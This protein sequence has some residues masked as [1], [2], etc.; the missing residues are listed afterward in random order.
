MMTPNLIILYVSDPLESARFYEKIL[1]K[2]AKGFPTY[3][4]F[5]FDGGFILGL[6]STSA[7]NFVSGGNGHRSELAFQVKSDDIVRHL[8]STWKADGVE[9]EQDLAEA[10]FGLTFVALD[11]DGHRIRVNLP[12]D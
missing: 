3:Q 8:Y 4:C 2:P 5:E 7:R 11:P 6:W 1:G 9:I 12:D 10:V